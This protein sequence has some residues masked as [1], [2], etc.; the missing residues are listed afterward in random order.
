MGHLS[1]SAARS[2]IPTF[3]LLDDMVTL[4]GGTK[5]SFYPFLTPIGT[6][7][8][9]YGSGNDG[10]VGLPN[11]AALEAEYDP[12]PLVGGIHGIYFDSDADNHILFAD[13]AAYSHV[14]GGNDTAFSVGAWVYMT[15]A[16]GSIRTIWGK[17][18]GAAEEYD[19]RLDASGFPELELHDASA[20]ATEVATSDDA[21]TPWKWNFVV[22]TYDATGGTSANA[23]IALY[24]D[25]SAVSAITLS[26]SGT[27]VD[28][29][30][31]AAVPMIAARNTTAAPAQEF[32]GYLALPFN[33]GKELTAAEVGSL[34]SIS[35]RL[36]GV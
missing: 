8:F 35:R 24:I 27:Y 22:A 16:L 19:F 21:V 20:S 32:E 26:D 1:S 5:M 33:T 10:L 25:G 12:I 6:D 4:L 17:Y 9:P 2:P 15:E 3:K 29:E 11:D 30:D 36:V 34:Y 28:M 13:N 14:T 7:V 18:S 31:G 23:G